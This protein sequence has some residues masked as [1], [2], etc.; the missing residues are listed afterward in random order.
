[1]GIWEF[2]NLGIFHVED[3]FFFDRLLGGYD[4]TKLI[5]VFLFPSIIQKKVTNNLKKTF[6]GLIS[7]LYFH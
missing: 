6:L 3:S 4:Y 5:W 2:G 1:L 7:G